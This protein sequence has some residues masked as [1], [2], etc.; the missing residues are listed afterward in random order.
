M[1]TAPSVEVS[2]NPE[3]TEV[4]IIVF[5]INGNSILI[6][7]KGFKNSGDYTL[8]WDGL[9]S[10]NEK[11]PSG[12]YIYRLILNGVEVNTKKMLLLY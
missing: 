2:E 12:L 10:E 1:G 6:L 4:S 11:M 8:K 3:N 9:N 7:E 5:D